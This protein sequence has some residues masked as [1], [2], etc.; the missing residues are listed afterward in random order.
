MPIETLWRF[1]AKYFPGWLPRYLVYNAPESFVPV[2]LSTLRAE[3]ITELPVIGRFLANDPSNRPG[4]M[5][6]ESLMSSERAE[7]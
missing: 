2:V 5:V 4:T 3:S 7:S 1:N 6:P